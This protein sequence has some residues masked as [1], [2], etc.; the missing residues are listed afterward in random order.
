MRIRILN[1]WTNQIEFDKECPVS[2]TFQEVGNNY[3]SYKLLEKELNTLSLNAIDFW[4]LKYKNDSYRPSFYLFLDKN[5]SCYTEG[6][7]LCSII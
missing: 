6:L 5:L 7:P 2:T 3:D 1:A 4:A